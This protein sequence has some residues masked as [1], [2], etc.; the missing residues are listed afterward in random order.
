MMMIG[1]EFEFSNSFIE[2]IIS[3]ARSN[4]TELDIVHHLVPE[5]T[6]TELVI[7]AGV[8][9][10]RPPHPGHG[11][12]HLGQCHMRHKTKLIIEDDIVPG[13]SDS[14]LD[15]RHQGLESLVTG[16]SHLTL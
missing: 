6:V 9:I 13:I 8:N 11:S 2:A 16:W 1:L 15:T 5:H 12:G 14:L 3:G 4:D 7:V 10:L